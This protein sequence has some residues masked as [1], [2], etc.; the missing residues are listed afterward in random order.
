MTGREA[1]DAWEKRRNKI[2]RETAELLWDRVAMI[3]PINCSPL[4]EAWRQGK[5]T[6][7]QLAGLDEL[8]GDQTRELMKPLLTSREQ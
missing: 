7:R 1:W 2:S 4:E 3:P 8:D 5:V 6:A